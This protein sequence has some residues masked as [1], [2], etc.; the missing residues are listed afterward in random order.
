MSNLV[1][2]IFIRA[3]NRQFHNR[4]PKPY[5]ERERLGAPSSFKN[6]YQMVAILMEYLLCQLFTYILHS[7]INKWYTLF[8]YAEH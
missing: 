3:C 1:L 5:W 7:L 2:E 8:N 6:I 4:L